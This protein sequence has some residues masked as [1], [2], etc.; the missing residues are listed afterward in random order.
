M[1]HCPEKEPFF[2]VVSYLDSLEVGYRYNFH[3][4]ESEDTSSLCFRPVDFSK[5]Q[6]NTMCS[7]DSTSF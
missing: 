6:L 4:L 7:I 2:Y 5:K 1:V 3:E